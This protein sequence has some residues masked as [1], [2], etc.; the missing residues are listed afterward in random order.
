MEINNTDIMQGTLNTSIFCIYKIVADSSGIVTL[1]STKKIL[2]N[3]IEKIRQL[4]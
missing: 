3:K 2:K 4:N 1:V